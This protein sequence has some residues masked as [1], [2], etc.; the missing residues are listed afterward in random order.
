MQHDVGNVEQRTLNCS[1]DAEAQNFHNGDEALLEHT[2]DRDAQDPLQNSSGKD[3]RF[4]RTL[5]L[6]QPPEDHRD[7]QHAADA[8]AQKRRPRNA[9]NAHSEY[10]HRK[11]VD[12]DVQHT[13]YRKV[14]ERAFSIAGRTQHRRAEVVHHVEG[15]TKEDNLNVGYCV[16]DL[17]FR[18][19]H[20]SQQRSCAEKAECTDKETADNADCH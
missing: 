2:R 4:F 13:R 7:R 12:T 19:A 18:R 5:N 11:N 3:R 14:N 6:G 1:R 17:R 16:V 8:L 20:K 15:R 9:R 10:S